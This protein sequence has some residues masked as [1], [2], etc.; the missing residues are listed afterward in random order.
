MAKFYN[1]KRR[2]VI[3]SDNDLFAPVEDAYFELGEFL[4]TKK[5]DGHD[6][7][8]QWYMLVHQKLDELMDALNKNPIDFDL[9]EYNELL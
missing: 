7:K 9:D 3:W 8:D 4:A 2:E 6:R 5:L 1:T